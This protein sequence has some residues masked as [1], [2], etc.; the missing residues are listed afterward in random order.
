MTETGWLIEHNDYRPVHRWL[1][2]IIETHPTLGPDVRLMWHEESSIALRFGREEDARAF[3]Y[4]HK[5]CCVDCRPT[6]HEWVANQ[7]LHG[8]AKCSD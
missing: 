4:L 6:E 1:R 7:A 3:M 5:D 2:A 8:D